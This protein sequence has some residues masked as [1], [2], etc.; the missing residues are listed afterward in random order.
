[1]PDP[2][3]I[4]AIGR[5][6]SAGKRIAAASVVRVKGSTPH[7]EGIALVVNDEEE[8]AGAF[9]G[10][11][12]DGEIVEACDAV[13]RSGDSKV[14]RFGGKQG[15]F[16][17]PGLLCGGEVEVWVYELPAAVA[18]QMASSA[19]GE[20]VLSINW[21]AEATHPDVS[22]LTS[23]EAREITAG[24]DQNRSST[25]L[26]PQIRAAE[27]L[28]EKRDRTAFAV[29]HSGGAVFLERFG[30]QPV[31]V[32]VGTSSYS[33]ALCRLG[34]F[35]GFNVTLCEPRLR[36][37][38]ETEGAAT[39]SSSWP[40]ACIAE[41]SAR[42]VLGAESAVIVCTHDS[43]FDELALTAAKRA[44]VGFIGA[45]GSRQTTAD[46]RRRL[47]EAGWTEEEI[48][49]VR[50]PVGLDIG[51]RTPAEAAVAVFAEIIQTRS[52]RTGR[53]LSSESGPLHG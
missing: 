5:W 38:R 11:C 28:L 9:S 26:S 48:A 53:A 41:L 22:Y 42:G 6:L 18:G 47:G 39:V 4:E 23:D 37:A 52:H 19:C 13:L 40:D 14:L 29:P 7:R 15:A 51:G 12:V 8:L 44:G 35:L 27:F 33:D 46:R 24:C 3:V 32:V 31:A 25:S 45:F 30:D 16:S 2:A 50:M 36:F 34:H 49:R 1:V 17:D 21:A 10:G 43:K 20:S